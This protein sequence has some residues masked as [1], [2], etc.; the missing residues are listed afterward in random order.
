VSALQPF[1]WECK[2]YADGWI[3]YF[4]EEEALAY[5]RDT[6]CALRITYRPAA[7]ELT[8]TPDGE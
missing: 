8:P 6:G 1:L 4:D 5:Q 3:R 7:P 2:D